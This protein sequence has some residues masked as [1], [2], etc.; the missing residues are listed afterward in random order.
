MIKRDN[1]GNI[2]GME[3]A[4][5]KL[6][7]GIDEKTL[8]ELAK[9]VEIEF[10]NQQQELILHFLVRGN[11]DLYADVAIATS[12]Q[13]AEEYCQQWLKNPIALEYI[14]LMDADSVNMSFWER[15]C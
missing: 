13:K 12:Q 10:L 2:G 6:K 8:V 11:D 4:M 1:I 14:E 3:F 7:P 15:I 9:K 5:F